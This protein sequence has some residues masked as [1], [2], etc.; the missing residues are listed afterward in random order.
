MKSKTG[1]IIL[2]CAIIAVIIIGIVVIYYRGNWEAGSRT[3]NERQTS[4][5]ELVIPEPTGNIDD[6]IDALV[7]EAT[8]EALSVSEEDGD[9]RAITEDNQAIDDLNQSIN[10][11]EL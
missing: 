11:N 3:Y 9:I 1:I 2:V 4:N 5:S 8:D 10:E 7:K 6:T